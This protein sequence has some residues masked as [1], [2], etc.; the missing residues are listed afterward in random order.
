MRSIGEERKRVISR[1]T[2]LGD[3]H[4][5]MPSAFAPETCFVKRGARSG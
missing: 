1:T 4:Y 2:I 3:K 5:E